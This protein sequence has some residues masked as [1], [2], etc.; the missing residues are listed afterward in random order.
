MRNVFVHVACRVFADRA[1]L[2]AQSDPQLSDVVNAPPLPQDLPP[3]LPFWMRELI[4]EMKKIASEPMSKEELEQLRPKLIPA[5]KSIEERAYAYRRTRAHLAQRSPLRRHPRSLRSAERNRLVPVFDSANIHRALMGLAMDEPDDRDWPRI[6]MGRRRSRCS[7]WNGHMRRGS[8]SF[9]AGWRRSRRPNRSLRTSSGSPT[10]SSGCFRTPAD[11]CVGHLTNPMK[12]RGCW[13]RIVSRGLA[14]RCRE[15]RRSG[16]A[17]PLSDL[18]RTGRQRITRQEIQ[19]G[20][21]KQ[22]QT[23]SQEKGRRFQVDIHKSD[24]VPQNQRKRQ[25]RNPEQ[26]ITNTPRVSKAVF[27]AV[28]GVVLISLD[29]LSEN[30]LSQQVQEPPQKRPIATRSDTSLLQK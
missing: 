12:S 23:I 25:E 5:H 1:E 26:R 14:I 29:R 20:C 4:D 9:M 2:E 17:Q 16:A 21:R 11:S 15:P 22:D 30:R 10:S 6:T 19:D 3:P 24:R 27:H 8:P 28:V 13:R 7:E 18:A